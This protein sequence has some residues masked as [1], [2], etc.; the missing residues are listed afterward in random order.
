MKLSPRLARLLSQ[1]AAAACLTF[2]VIGAAAQAPAAAYPTRAI[3]LIVPSAAGG[4]LDVSMRH[5]ARRLSDSLGVP[6]VV[7]NRP[8]VN[9][10][11]S[12]TPP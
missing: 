12:L 5:V 6:V 3:T 10:M 1:T 8:N 11:L 7:E 2:A 9:L 4:G